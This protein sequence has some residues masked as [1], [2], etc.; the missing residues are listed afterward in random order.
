MN[1]AKP[2]T[3]DVPDMPPPNG[4]Y[5]YA[6]EHG[7]VI[8]ASGQLGRGPGM[9]DLEAGDISQQTRRSLERLEKVL[10]AANSDLSGLLKVNITI[11]NMDDWP[12]VNA[13]Y[14]EMLGTHRPARAVIAAKSLHFDAL[15]EIEGIA[16]VG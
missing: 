9:T 11:V 16:A 10:R 12:A 3:V 13:I 4:H 14:S 6:I 7:G 1:P 8:Y 5:A 15:I 2:R